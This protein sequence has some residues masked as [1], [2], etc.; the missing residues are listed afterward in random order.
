MRFHT[1][2][3]L[4]G[5]VI[6]LSMLACTQVVAPPS[7]SGMFTAVAATPSP[8]PATATRRAAP[9]ATAEAD[10]QT[11]VVLPVALNVRQSP[12]GA[13]TNKYLYS[14]DPV[15]VGVCADKWCEIVATIDGQEVTGFVYQ[16]CLSEVAGELRCEAR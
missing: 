16:G 7:V 9:S 2:I 4:S 5:V 8:V 1:R 11:A 12:G 13:S 10:V 6:L 15:E 3:L 14:G